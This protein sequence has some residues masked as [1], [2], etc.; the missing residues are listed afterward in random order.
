LVRSLS[1]ILDL[2]TDTDH[3]KEYS[4]YLANKYK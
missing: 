2:P 1:G 3:K 4:D